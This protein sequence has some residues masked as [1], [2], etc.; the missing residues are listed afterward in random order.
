[1]CCSQPT[2]P[3][4]RPLSATRSR[5]APWGL[6]L[7]HYRRWRLRMRIPGFTQIES[8]S[9]RATSS[10]TP[11]ALS[12]KRACAR[13][14]KRVSWACSSVRKCC[15]VGAPS[16]TSSLRAWGSSSKWIEAITRAAVQRMRVVIASCAGSGIGSFG[17]RLRWCFV[18][19]LPQ[20]QSSARHS[21]C[22]GTGECS[23]SNTTFQLARASSAAL[24]RPTEAA[25][26]AAR[27]IGEAVASR[28]S[29]VPGWSCT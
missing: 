16:W 9:A 7:A 3:V 14:S 23:N 15:S 25:I 10:A 2:P 26:R 19:S 28:A 29:G 11:L 6:R 17:W 22:G 1:M 27:G 20:S 12:R 8:S 13:R 4:C 24:T 5:P 21:R 18:T